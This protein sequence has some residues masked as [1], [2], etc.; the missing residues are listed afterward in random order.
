MKI[1]PTGI[2]GMDQVLNGGFNHPSTVLVAG[3]A[4]AGKTTFVMQSLFNAA[5]EGENCLFISA[6]SEPVAMMESFV[7]NYSFF[8]YSLIEKKKIR[9]FNIEESMLKAG[10]PEVLKFIE[11]KI[12]MYKPNRLVIDPV[13]VLAESRQNE[14]EKRLFLFE[15][16]TRMKSWNLLVLLT[17]EFSLET[18]KENPASYL[19]DCVI[20]ISEVFIGD[21]SERYLSVIKMRGRNYISG[22]HTYKLDNN[23]I[24]VFPRLLPEMEFRRQVPMSRVSTGVEGLDLMLKG[25]M[26]RDSVILFSGSPGTGKTVFGLHFIREGA[27]KGEPGLIISFEEWPEKIIR[28]AATLGWDFAQFEQKGLVKFLHFSPIMYHADEHALLIKDILKQHGIRRIFFDGIENLETALPDQIKRRDYIHALVNYFSAQDVTTLLTSEIPELFG[29]IRLTHEALSGTFDVIVLL[30]HV[31][32]EGQMRKALSLL[33]SRGSD[34]DKEIREYEITNKGIVV[35]VAIKGYE[36]VLVGMARKP[37][38]DIFME[39]FGGKKS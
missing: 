11:E 38:A 22:R 8:D 29:T 37:A 20:H 5:K 1:V 6:I 30:R 12:R 17:G 36:N 3:T 7:S 24:S 13:T 39:L 33:K 34:H 28:N 35:K 18:L 21:K 32:V 23:G 31:E 14:L 2:K 25:G 19:V 4:G 16:L 27:M 10:A 26:L 15:L 9:L